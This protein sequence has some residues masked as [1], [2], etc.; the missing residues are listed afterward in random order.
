MDEN[1]LRIVRMKGCQLM[2]SMKEALFLVI[3]LK[4][5]NFL[6]FASWIVLNLATCWKQMIL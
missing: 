4:I 2:G 3:V 5:Q 6:P 1:G